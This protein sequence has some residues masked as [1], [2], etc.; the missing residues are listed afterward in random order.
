MRK[1]SELRVASDHQPHLLRSDSSHDPFSDSCRVK[2]SETIE[3]GLVFGAGIVGELRPGLGAA[4]DHGFRPGRIDI[5]DADAIARQ[6]MR[7]GVTD[8]GRSTSDD[9][10]LLLHAVPPDHARPDP[11]FTAVNKIPDMEIKY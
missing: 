5:Q 10:N 4:R 7:Q 6:F 9:D 8:A 2:L 3:P 1:V 11:D